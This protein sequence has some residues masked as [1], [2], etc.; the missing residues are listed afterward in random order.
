VSTPPAKSRWVKGQSGNPSGRAKDADVR[1]LAREHTKA[2]MD[3]LVQAL[4][5][6]STRVQAAVAILDRGWGKPAQPVEGSLGL[7]T[8]VAAM[9]ARRRKPGD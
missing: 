9:E 6:S 4:K 3:A 2:A 7:E 8:L 1:A 5:T